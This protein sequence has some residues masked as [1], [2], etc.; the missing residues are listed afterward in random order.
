MLLASVFDE[1]AEPYV[2]AAHA[3]AE[4]H[5]WCYMAVEGVKPNSSG[6]IPYSASLDS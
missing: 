2:R 3:P 6:G 1:L 5:F 4:S